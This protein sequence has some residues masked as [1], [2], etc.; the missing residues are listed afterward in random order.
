[1]K[2]KE[3]LWKVKV[4]A[5]PVELRPAGKIYIITPY[6]LSHILRW[7]TH[8]YG[9]PEASFKV[10]NISAVVIPADAPQIKDL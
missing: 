7:L 8:Q 6:G 1:M 2:D 5:D 3:K 4:E 10:K 9:L